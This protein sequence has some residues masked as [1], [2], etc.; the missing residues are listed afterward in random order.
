MKSRHGISPSNGPTQ[1]M[2]PA[3]DTD[4]A[5]LE[6]LSRVAQRFGWPTAQAILDPQG[7]GPAHQAQLLRQKVETS[8]RRRPDASRVRV[9]LLTR[10]AGANTTEDPLAV[11]CFFPVSPSA[12][13]LR[14]AHRLAWSFSRAR[15]LL[16]VEPA[17][18]RVWTCCEAP[19][20]T[21][22][23]HPFPAELAPLSLANVGRETEQAV[24]RSLEW[25]RF[26][27]GA[28][29]TVAPK[30]FRSQQCA[31]RTL[32]ENCRAVRRALLETISGRPGLTE[33]IAHDLL[34]RILFVQFL[35]H[36]RDSNGRP[37]LGQHELNTLA[38]DGVLSECYERLGQI[39]LSHDD[40]Y[41]LFRW[42][43]QRFNG[44]LFPGKRHGQS[45]SF[46][47]EGDLAWRQEME[48][49]H[50]AHLALLA[51]LVEGRLRL[52]NG[53]AQLHL[54]PLYA[55]D[56]L[57]LEFISSI[58]EELVGEGTGVHYTPHLLV[59]FVLDE[60]LPWD[61]DT[62]DIKI[63]DPA[64]GSGIFLV[65]A[66][67]RLVY[68]FRR[69]NPG[70]SPTA[71]LLR[72]LLER[73]L[74]GVD[75]D[76]NAVRVAS[77]SLYLAMCDE[78][79]AR[80]YWKTMRLPSLYGIRLLRADFFSQEKGS[81][82]GLDECAGAFDLVVG[83][84]PWGEETL[85][86]AAATWAREQGWDVPNR[87]IGPLFLIKGAAMTAPQGFVA[88][89]QPAG[90]LLYNRT[91]VACRFRRQLFQTYEVEEVVDFSALRHNSF[92]NS[93]AP[94]CAVILQPIPPDDSTVLF[95]RARGHLEG[96][97][98]HVIIIETSDVHALEKQE[99]GEDPWVWSA[100][101]H[102]SRRD[103]Q[104]VHRLAR[105]PRSIGSLGE[106]RMG[107][108]RGSD[109]KKRRSE[110]TIVGRRILDQPD[111][112][113]D[114]FLTLDADTLPVN[115]DPYVTKRESRDL[116]A[117][118]APQ[119]LMKLSRVQGAHRFR[120]VVVDNHGR[121]EGVVC[122]QSYRSLCVNET[123]SDYLHAACLMLNSAMAAYFL[124]LTG[125]RFAGF[126]P[127]ALNQELDALPVPGPWQGDLVALRSFAD[128]DREVFDLL[129]LPEADRVRIE[130]FMDR[131]DTHN[132][133]S[134]PDLPAYCDQLIRT[135]E[136]NGLG[137]SA[138]ILQDARPTDSPLCIVVLY[139]QTLA[140]DRIRIETVSEPELRERLTLLD[141]CFLR[142]QPD[143]QGA[144][145]VFFHRVA[146]IYDV[147]EV[148]DQ[149]VPAVYLVKP[150]RRDCWT[151][152]AALDDA[153][154]LIA[155]ALTAGR[156]HPSG[157]SASL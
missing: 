71:Q 44:D 49:V 24:L 137:T 47:M 94:I 8:L 151:R 11:V 110:P 65:K 93:I 133:L 85:T 75:I 157:E 98:Q 140:G 43:D 155:E 27:S 73:N 112:P 3:N 36:R 132:R 68:R 60:V 144:G 53:G 26:T 96:G 101:W 22:G 113:A 120:A 138:V 67:Q 13:T 91:Q 102:G 30:R 20:P 145:G 41:G 34:A 92:E 15:A 129:R 28:L 12:E 81:P 83:N 33:A 55:F 116:S 114:V 108:V 154:G 57:P 38:S 115:A 70:V 4:A 87:S 142:Q 97:S 146:R 29:F 136:Q 63:L 48:Q 78:M 7:A 37:A 39:L 122:R 152:S 76:D 16:I 40:T 5:D 104:L 143:G 56:A 54:W 95:A 121:D 118:Q 134:A 14:E 130:D 127:T 25:V 62:W 66:F 89:L 103:L 42:L 35:F 128:V 2:P 69:A 139:L 21:S 125:S 84:A 147:A 109:P 9:G 59:D 82:L 50:P 79:D 64:C 52:K 107:I 105:L 141:R 6:P 1:K 88:M 18:L 80:S 77:L 45:G 117:F 23:Q 148:G 131:Q 106:R 156:P 61:G 119:L 99:S 126:I 51:D 86:T 90:A 149:R 19:A 31:D 10:D 17:L 58:Y 135:L 46:Q 111:F 150:S 32:L 72:R 74:M 123:Q 100:L 124:T 153:D